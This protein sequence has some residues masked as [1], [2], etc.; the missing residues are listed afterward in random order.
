MHCVACITQP[1]ESW[2][3]RGTFVWKTWGVCVD[4]L[5][6]TQIVRWTALFR[7][8]KKTFSAGSC[9]TLQ[10][11][12]EHLLLE[13]EAWAVTSTLRCI[14]TDGSYRYTLWI[15]GQPSSGGCS[16]L[17]KPWKGWDKVNLGV[18]KLSHAFFQWARKTRPAWS[19]ELPLKEMLA[20]IKLLHWCF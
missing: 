20:L 7:L 10:P 12:F 15:S 14:I 5:S 16:R 11:H 8:K 19:S 3:S 18:G 4:T 2:I 17:T 13:C 6:V 9:L 1:K